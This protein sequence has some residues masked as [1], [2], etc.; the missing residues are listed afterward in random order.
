MRLLRELKVRLPFS[1]YIAITL[2]VDSKTK[3][4]PLTEN[5]TL[6]TITGENGIMFTLCT[7]AA[8]AWTDDNHSSGRPL[9]VS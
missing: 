6:L 3:F 2:L 4:K 9:F 1:K 8:W 7:I 5:R